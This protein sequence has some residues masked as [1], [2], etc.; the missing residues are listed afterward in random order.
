MFLSPNVVAFTEP[1]DDPW[2]SVHRGPFDYKTAGGFSGPSTTQQW[3]AD[4]PTN[5]LGCTEQIQVC[6]PN[7]SIPQGCGPVPS[8][9]SLYEDLVPEV[10]LIS[11]PWH[12]Q[13]QATQFRGFLSTWS[14]FSFY[15]DVIIGSLRSKSLAS[16]N[17]LLNGI[18]G[19][20][21]T[22]Q[23]QL[24]VEDWFST[25]LASLQRAFAETANGPRYTDIETHL[26]PPQNS[27]DRE[28]CKNQVR[29]ISTFQP[30]VA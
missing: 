19:A 17:N 21:S 22:N 5:V 3:F 1:L 16:R 10:P 11:P 24:D 12:D 6:D 30:L 4:N 7:L 23:W 28:F 18:Q 9:T 2:Y 13:T 29:S 27:F 20:L 14:S 8:P 26:W 15:P 25:Q